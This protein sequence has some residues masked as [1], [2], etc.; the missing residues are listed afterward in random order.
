MG[1]ADIRIALAVGI[2]LV[3]VLV[4]DLGRQGIPGMVLAAE[5]LKIDGLPKA[6][7]QFRAH[8][9]QILASVDS[10]IEKL[11][12]D[13]KNRAV[14]LDLLQTRDDILRELP[15]IDSKQGDARWTPTD[16][17]ESV[18]SKLKLLKEQYDKAA[19][20]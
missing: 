5:P 10:L 3:P 8:V 12:K 4:A 9:E 1:S 20:T 2:L 11:K 15:K 16:M 18:E 19:G 6:P 7:Q 13:P 17:R 14:V